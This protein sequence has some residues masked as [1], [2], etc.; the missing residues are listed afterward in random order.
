[1]K[2]IGLGLPGISRNR[3]ELQVFM[4]EFGFQ[5]LKGIGLGFPGILRNRVRVSRY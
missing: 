3:L 4:Q 2:G 5:V 1:L